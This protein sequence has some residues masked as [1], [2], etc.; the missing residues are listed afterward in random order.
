[1][2]FLKSGIFLGVSGVYLAL[3]RSPGRL[4]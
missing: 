4:P 3:A 2:G 1:M